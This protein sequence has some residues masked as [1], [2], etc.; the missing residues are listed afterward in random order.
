MNIVELIFSENSSHSGVALVEGSR[1]VSYPELFKDICSL[2][3]QLEAIGIKRGTYVVI[4]MRGGIDYILISLAVLLCG[5]VIV[6]IIETSGDEE[7]KAVLKIAAA[8]LLISGRT[9]A[10]LKQL[11]FKSEIFPKGIVVSQAEQLVMHDQRIQAIDAAFVRFSSGTTGKSKGIVLSH[12]AIQARTDAADKVLSMSRNDRVIW[13]LNMSFHFVVTIV[14]FLRRGSTI[15]ICEED[16]PRSF[17]NTVSEG[18][19]TFLYASPFHYSL[20]AKTEGLPGNVFRDVRLAIS[21]AMSL[22]VEVAENFHAKFGIYPSQAYGIIE[23]GLPCVN[24]SQDYNRIL[25]V[26]KL[27]PDYRLKLVDTDDH[28]CGRIFLKGKGMFDAYLQPIRLANE[29]LTDGWFDTGDIGEEDED[30][31]L[32]I[33]G[34]T[35]NVINFCGMKVFPEEVEAVLNRYPGIKESHVYGK[36]HPQYGQ[37]VCADIVTAERMILDDLRL[38]CYRKLAKYKVPK[39]FAFVD[40]L[41]KTASGKVRRSQEEV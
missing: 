30:G 17:I 24:T 12:C 10:G 21:T 18:V 7:I 40:A 13:V 2:A 3:R 34:R 39:E 5:G 37:I 11:V 9:I 35:K 36:A 32:F 20:L 28:G 15:V 25:S 27:L 26:G 6:P 1:S 22:S 29:V 23:V 38:D 41:S 4:C 8:E 33:T 31:Y 16:F 19:P 14:L